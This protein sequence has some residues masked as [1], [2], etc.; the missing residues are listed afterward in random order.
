MNVTVIGAGYVGLVT[1]T[2][3]AE[4]GYHVYCMVTDAEKIS[5]L[6]IGKLPIHEPGLDHLV[7]ENLQAKRL[8]FGTDIDKGIDFGDVLF[9]AVG[10]PPDEDGSADLSHVLEVAR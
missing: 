3:L 10:T 7:E 5:G 6:K 8:E 2:C 4:V 9:I 1:G